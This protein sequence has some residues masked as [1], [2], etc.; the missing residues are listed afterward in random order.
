MATFSPLFAASASLEAETPVTL[1]DP[2]RAAPVGEP[3]ILR[4]GVA[5]YAGHTLLFA[6]LGLGG[7]ALKSPARAAVRRVGIEPNAELPGVTELLEI[8]PLP[9]GLRPVLRRLRGLP[10]FYL[11]PFDITI[12]DDTIIDGD[13]AV[14]TNV[15]TAFVAAVFPD[16]LQLAP[17]AW[18]QLI[19]DALAAAQDPEAA[20][21]N[22]CTAAL[23]GGVTHCRVLDHAGRP[24]AM[25]PE[26]AVS[27]SFTVRL[28]EVAGNSLVAERTVTLGEDSDLESALAAAPGS[29]TS[30]VAP[31]GRYVEIE[32][33]G[34]PRTGD[35]AAVVAAVYETR[36]G[37][38]PENA[39]APSS[40]LRLPAAPRMTVQVLDLS[41]WLAPIAEE[42]AIA[43]YRRG[44]QVEPLVDGIA[45]FQRLVADVRGAVGPG[46]G[47]YLAG[48]TFNRFPL[49]PTMSDADIVDLMENLHASGALVRVL[50]TKMVNLRDPNIDATRSLALAAIAILGEAAYFLSVILESLEKS[51]TNAVG[52]LA[53]LASP[54]LAALLAEALALPGDYQWL[55]DEVLESATGTLEDVNSVAPGSAFFS[56]NPHRIAD[57]PL[58]DTLTDPLWGLEDDVDQFNVWH[59]KSQ[60]VKRIAAAGE[61]G[62]V[63][64]LG[65]IDI[66]RNRFDSPGHGVRGPYHDVHSRVTGPIVRDVFVSFEERWRVNRNPWDGTPLPA[67]G[68][69]LPQ[70]PV[71][72]SRPSRHVAK[73]GRTYYG[74]RNP[75]SA[76][77]QFAKHGDAGIYLTLLAAIASAREYIYIED[78]YFTPDDPFIDVLLAAREHCRR[79]VI[80]LPGET[81]QPFGD[82]RRRLVLARLRGTSVADGW[83]DRMLVGHPQR[84]P[85]LP[86]SGTVAAAGRCS[87]ARACSA[88]D[89]TIFVAPHARV[90]PTPFWLWIDGELMLAR[91]TDGPVAEGGLTATRVEVIRGSA[92][93]SPRWGATTRAHGLGA[94]VTMSMVKGVYV[95]A[96]TM[97]IDDTFVSIGSANLNRRGFFSDGEINVFAIPEQLRAAPDNPA[98]S[99]RTALWAEHLGIPPA[100][101]PALLEDPIAGF[102]LFRR[103]PRLGNRFTPLSATNPKSQFTLTS[104]VQIALIEFI[105]MLLGNAPLLPGEVDDVLGRL[106][107]I[108]VDATSRTDPDPRPGLV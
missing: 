66:N 31:P 13:Q 1:P 2:I 47:V 64:Y 103:S 89:D 70:P 11:T 29:P 37:V 102:D 14:A 99:L 52:M 28:R 19:G 55:L 8:A 107:D 106:W 90:G 94:P 49:D 101:G 48:W 78:Q 98:R 74:P 95:H 58:A 65:G 56:S 24:L 34:A 22:A 25:N 108:G 97:M 35:V 32:W 17:W 40:I 80:L 38:A 100:M 57:N 10:T 83:G 54:A 72:A 39:T 86:A 75:A 3:E 18:M 36:D 27:K 42:T 30:V 76:P 51:D 44:C 21:W 33:S 62:W 77:L 71:D 59:N 85:M 96:K 84:R 61:N 63:G 20:D 9:F 4:P 68:N 46:N 91:R 105:W 12:E 23:Y 81:D 6:R 87:L 16:G 15:S 26:P 73:V 45:S 69:D 7:T 67:A 79:L 53:L 93:G 50:C 88:N 43:R 41:R 5:R 60:M 92:P 82:N 104:T